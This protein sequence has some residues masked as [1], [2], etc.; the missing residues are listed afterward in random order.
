MVKNSIALTNNCCTQLSG[1]RVTFLLLGL[2]AIAWSGYS[3][4]T[5]K[6][7]YKG[8]PPGGFDRNRDPVSYW[9]PTFIILVIGVCAILIFLGVI[10]LPIR[11][12]HG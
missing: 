11:S 3:L 5:G 7:Y 2:V 12:E 1:A 6:G 10:T 4:V 8:C 9:A